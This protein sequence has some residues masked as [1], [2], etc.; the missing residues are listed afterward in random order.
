MG[1]EMCI[2]DSFTADVSQAFLRGLTFEQA[3]QMK[4]EVQRDVQF[5]VP[6]GSAQI[7]Q[8]LPG[9]EDFNPLVEVFR[10]L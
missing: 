9:F 2:R 7:L 3:A 6:P 10:M 4:D 1:S 8:R 5:T